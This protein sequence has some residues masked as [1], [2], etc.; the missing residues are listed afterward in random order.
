MS[1]PLN[2]VPP[3]LDPAS[4]HPGR[5]KG[6]VGA[7]GFGRISIH[8]PYAPSMTLATVRGG[9][10]LTASIG[11]ALID[12]IAHWPAWLERRVEEIEPMDTRAFR[13]RVAFH[14]NL[15]TLD[16]VA[17]LP[18]LDDHYLLPL[19]LLPRSTV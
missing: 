6:F 17:H 11:R 7:S 15:S 14:V 8:V 10:L 19:C 18:I 4:W 16:R 5:P 1:R 9:E 2:R 12:A 13:R 3:S